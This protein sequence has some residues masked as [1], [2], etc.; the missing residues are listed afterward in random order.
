LAVLALC[1]A[2]PPIAV[3]QQVAP[4]RPS[5]DAPN[6][7]R[8]AGEQPA[9]AQP[10]PAPAEIAEWI[11]ALDDRQYQVR[12]RATQK[13]LAAREAALDPLLV[14]ANGDRPEPAER[15]L[16]VLR[17]VAQSEEPATAISALERLAQ[18][19]D[20]PNLVAQARAELARRA[21]LAC[22]QHLE[23]LGAECVVQLEQ[24][25]PTGVITQVFHVRLGEKWRGNTEDLRPL[26]ELRYQ[27]HIR[28]EGVPVN[29]AVAKL[30]EARDELA[31]L[32]LIGTKVSVAAVD[33]LKARHPSADVYMKNQAKMG[34]ACRN[35]A[36]GAA[37]E[38]VQSGTAADRAGVVVGDIITAIDGKPIPDFDRL[39]AHVAQK[40]PSDKITIEVLRGEEKKTLSVTLGSWA[41]VD[42]R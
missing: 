27:S 4:A 36:A 15:A 25:A 6:S 31:W 16:S 3:A 32:Q 8:L 35:H 17:R 34:V 12:E 9:T 14:A 5:A 10:A 41:E 21:V 19:R 38:L 22:Q 7:H 13:L 1:W 18:L 37:V 23:S 24:V 20:R 42:G 30:F 28:L 33:A 26:A 2:G 40:Q 11:A 29:D 39:T